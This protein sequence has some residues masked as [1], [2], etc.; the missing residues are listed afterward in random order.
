M[1]P[2]PDPAP[3][4]NELMSITA[5]I[6][7]LVRRQ[8]RDA[9]TEAPLSG[10]QVE[11]LQVVEDQPGIGVAAAAH[12]LHLANNSVSTLV[13]RLVEQALLRRTVDPADRR[14][15]QLFLTPT[16]TRRL[17]EWRQA[18]AVLVG[19]RIARLPAADQRAIERAL[20]S[21]RA[22]LDLLAAEHT[23]PKLATVPM[24]EGAR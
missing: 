20:P 2:R 18:R 21:L 23:H 9:S 17:A 24:T 22:L 16:V 15:A 6:R 8:L 4:A 5:G 13:N 3:L 11:L 12:A 14:A 19:D 10:T 7:R 1:H